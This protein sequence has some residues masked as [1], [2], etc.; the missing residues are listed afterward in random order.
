MP[1][2]YRTHEENHRKARNNHTAEKQVVKKKFLK[3]AEESPLHTEKKK[4]RRTAYFFSETMQSREQWSKIF[5]L[6]KEKKKVNLEF[7]LSRENISKVEMAKMF[8][9]YAPEKFHD[10]RTR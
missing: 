1:P 8:S 9:D 7:S 2:K 3:A 4:P 10:R 6:K 5:S